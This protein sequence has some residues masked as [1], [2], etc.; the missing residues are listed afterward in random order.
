VSAR[1]TNMASYS[2]LRPSKRPAGAGSFALPPRQFALA[3]AVLLLVAATA[4]LALSELARHR[5]ASGG[6]S[7]P[8]F[9]T[10][11]LGPAR[12][13]ASLVRTPARSVAVSVEDDGFRVADD[14]GSVAVVPTASPTSHWARHANGAMRKTP[15][16][17]EAVVFDGDRLG[18]ESYL[19]VDRRQGRRTWRWRLDTTFAPRVTP[20]GVVGFFKGTKLTA[21]WVPAVKILDRNGH[22]V[23]PRGAKWHTLQR[24]G[25]WWLELTLNDRKLPLPY[26]IDPAVLQTNGTGTVA[27]GTG[28]GTTYNVVYPAGTVAQDLD[29][30]RD[31]LLAEGGRR[32]RRHEPVRDTRVGCH[33]GRRHA[34]LSRR[35]HEPG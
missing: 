29:A 23:T 2:K 11:A 7:T 28:A 35:R 21:S 27:F 22:D 5:G 9:L 16:G 30:R 26:T 19:V 15:F 13:H 12:P 8:A 10:K 1:E 14:D 6:R 34:G 32:P 18:A 25:S 31:H 3:A 33:S 17:R 4:A 24:H 20:Q